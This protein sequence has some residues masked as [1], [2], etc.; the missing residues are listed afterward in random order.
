MGAEQE[1]GDKDDEGTVKGCGKGVL[2]RERLKGLGLY[3]KLPEERSLGTFKST[4]VARQQIS[5]IDSE[6]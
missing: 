4:L 1:V 2:K 5:A 6:M 3:H